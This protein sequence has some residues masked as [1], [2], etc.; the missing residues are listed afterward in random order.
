MNGPISFDGCYLLNRWRYRSGRV[1]VSS[2]QQLR[3]C[4]VSCLVHGLGLGK[5]TM[6]SRMRALVSRPPAQLTN[7]LT[8]VHPPRLH[9]SSTSVQLP[10]LTL[11][12]HSAACSRTGQIQ[13]QDTHAR[14]TVIQ[15]VSAVPAKAASDLC[16]IKFTE[17]PC[18][19]KHGARARPHSPLIAAKLI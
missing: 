8:T 12:T 5:G 4:A 15:S 2:L 3:R 10:S 13:V 18:R 11:H 6:S 14:P 16:D 9:L 7:R 19:R 1:V 17:A